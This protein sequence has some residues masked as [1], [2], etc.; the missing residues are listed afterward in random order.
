MAAGRMKGGKTLTSGSGNSVPGLV[1]T[2]LWEAELNARE[3]IS[4][5]RASTPFWL[6]MRGLG[7]IAATDPSM[8]PR[9]ASALESVSCI[10]VF[11]PTMPIIVRVIMRNAFAICAHVVG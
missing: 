3:D 10:G 9:I 2:L 4:Q 8:R 1:D 5:M 11:H 7:V 6:R